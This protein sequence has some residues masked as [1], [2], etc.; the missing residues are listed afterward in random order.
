MDTALIRIARYHSPLTTPMR[1]AGATFNARDGMFVEVTGDAG[2]G[3]GEVAPLPGVHRESLDDCVAALEH[4]STFP[5]ALAFGMSVA[6]AIAAGDPV[7]CRP[8]RERVGVNALI[9]GAADQ[10]SFRNARTIK[11]KIGRGAVAT[12]RAMLQQLMLREPQATIR[13]DG[14][15]SMTLDDCSELLTGLD[16]GRIDYLEEP[17]IDPFELPALHFR[18]GCSIALDESLHVPE[19]RSALETAPGVTTHVIKPTLIGSLRAVRERAERTARQG[20]HTTVTSTFESSYTL[21][22]L[23]RL[24]TWL[25]AADG[26]HG[27][28]TAGI[29]RDDPCDP[30]VITD[31]WMRTDEPLDCVRLGLRLSWI[32]M[33]PVHGD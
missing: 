17:L 4:G 11:V 16:R 14:N 3:I 30:P 20:L 7:L 13:L 2:V 29:L 19:H 33:E 28:A 26:D 18:T 1:F 27:L 24:I 15:R 9:A 22:V 25:P 10:R 12:E 32:S 8:L 6:H 5:P 23:A 31:G 21:R